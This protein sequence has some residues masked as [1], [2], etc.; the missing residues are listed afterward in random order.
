MINRSSK[1]SAQFNYK[2][3][4]LN[5][6]IL[7]HMHVPTNS[8][9]FSIGIWPLHRL[10]GY[11]HS[12]GNWKQT[13]MKEKKS[14]NKTELLFLMFYNSRIKISFRSQM[15]LKNFHSMQKMLIW[16]ETKSRRS[17][18]FAFKTACCMANPHETL[19]HLVDKLFVTMTKPYDKWL[20]YKAIS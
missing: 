20:N 1:E 13:R 16:H 7:I 18:F 5:L 14:S 3:I 2:L 9:K 11:C 8:E 6:D 15:R 10:V 19:W 4:K 17:F 12:T